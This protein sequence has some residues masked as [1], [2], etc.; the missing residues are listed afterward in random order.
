M[1]ERGKKLI[2]YL[3]AQSNKRRPLGRPKHRWE[4][5]IQIFLKEIKSKVMD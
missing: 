2:I 4:E 1:Y 5:N 3:S